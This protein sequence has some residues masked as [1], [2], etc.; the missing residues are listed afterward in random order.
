MG[1]WDVGQQKLHLNVL[2]RHVSFQIVKLTIS[3]KSCLNLLTHAAAASKPLATR[4]P[5]SD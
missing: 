2:Y 5:R 3:Y 1:S 4:S